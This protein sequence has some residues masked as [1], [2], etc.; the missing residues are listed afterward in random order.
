MPSNLAENLNLLKPT[1]FKITIDSSQYANLEF[2]I[3]SISFPGVNM[4]SV[5]T[6]FRGMNA[7]RE[8]EPI[9]YEQI[10]ITCKVDEDLNAWKEVF[11]WM[12]KNSGGE[13]THHDFSLMI[14]TSHN[15]ANVNIRFANAFPISLSGFEL[16]VNE[17]TEPSFTFTL[18]YD[19]YDF[20]H[21]S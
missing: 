10:S 1:G 9:E 11:Y 17:D 20:Q 6:P 8:G 3:T 13:I 21:N 16:N 19:Y 14:L 12:K 18:Q 5:T 2:F 15:N 7:F 4:G